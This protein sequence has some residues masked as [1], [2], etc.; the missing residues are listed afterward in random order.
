MNSKTTL[1][2][3]TKKKVKGVKAKNIYK[4]FGIKGHMIGN[5]VY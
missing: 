4:H 2:T 5:Q 3:L 1:Q